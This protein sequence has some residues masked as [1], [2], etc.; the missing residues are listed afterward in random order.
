MPY[1]GP[2]FSEDTR[3]G[4]FELMN[5]DRMNYALSEKSFKSFIWLVLAEIFDSKV[6]ILFNKLQILW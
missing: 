4:I 2:F 6:D 1:F 3:D 5:S